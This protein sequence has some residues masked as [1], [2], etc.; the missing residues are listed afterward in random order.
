M[1]NTKTYSNSHMYKFRTTVRGKDSKG[2]DVL[3][4]YLTQED[5]AV[6]IG[7]LTAQLENPKGAKIVIHTDKK[8]AE[9]TNRHFDSSFGFVSG[10]EENGRTAPGAA[11]ARFVPKA[12][13]AKATSASVAK[14]INSAKV[15]S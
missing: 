5:V 8:T 1:N 15:E 14:A 13:P 10:V 9:G 12:A 6:M 4:V 2:R 11:P 7:E 3:K